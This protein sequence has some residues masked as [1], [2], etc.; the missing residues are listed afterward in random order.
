M[1]LDIEMAFDKISWKFINFMLHKK[2]F[3]TKWRKW[4]MACI[5][6]VQYSILINGKLRGA[7]KT[8]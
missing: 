4:I 7:Y 8:K 1:K 3:P 5:T 2:G 6:S